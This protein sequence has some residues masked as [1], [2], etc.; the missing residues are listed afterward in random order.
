MVGG[1][2]GEV[3]GGGVVELYKV[4]LVGW[5]HLDSLPHTHS[6]MRWWWVVGGQWVVGRW[7]VVGGRCGVGCLVPLSTSWSCVS[8]IV[9]I[10][11][12]SPLPH[13]S[14]PPLFVPLTLLM[15]HPPFLTVG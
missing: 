6:L 2:G 14:P 12:A 13:T 5:W 10:A 8:A 15:N 7:S 4:G 1:C 9:T 3:V 11:T